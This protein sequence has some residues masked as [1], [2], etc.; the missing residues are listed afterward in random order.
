MDGTSAA[1]ATARGGLHPFLLYSALAL[2]LV[3]SGLAW[4]LGYRAS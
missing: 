3:E 2:L 4:Y 1:L